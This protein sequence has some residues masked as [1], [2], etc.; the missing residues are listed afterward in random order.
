MNGTAQEFD[1]VV[2]GAGSA[3]CA[4]AARLAETANASVALIEAGPNDHHYTVSAP[5]GIAATVPREGP[6]NYAFHTEPQAG[7]LGR[8]SY[9]PRGRGLG[10]SSSINGMVYIRG[11]RVDFDAWANAGCTGWSYEDVLPY[12]R[13]SESNERCTGRDDDPCHGSRGPVQVSELRSPNPFS[14]HFIAAAL[15]AGLKLNPDFNGVDQEGVGL[16]Q[17]TQR[18]GERWNTARAYLHGGNRADTAH[19]GGRECL[20]VLTG[21][22]AQR[23][24][25]E[26][27]RAAAVE[28]WRDGVAQTVRV[29]REIVVSAGTFHSPQ[30]LMASGIGPAAHLREFGIEVVCDAPQV[31]QNLQD[32]LDIIVNKQVASTELFGRSVPGLMRLAREIHRYRR[33]RTGMITSN[34]AEAGAFV[35]SAPDLAAPDL[36]LHFVPAML[37]NR[38]E[39]KPPRGHGYSCHACVLRPHS[40]GEVTLRSPHMHDAP[41]ID[42]RFLADERDMAGMVA[43]VKLVRRIFAQDALARHGGREL[44][45]DDIAREAEDDEAIRAFVRR[46]ADTVYHPVGTCRMGADAQSVVDPQL[47]VRGVAGLRVVDASVMPTLVGGNTNAAAIMIAEKAADL[48]RANI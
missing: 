23:I 17:V 45:T 36:Q 19:N 14:Q 47:R 21:A 42:P 33:E 26:G 30:L 4:I 18:N 37:G 13:R 9:Q 12:F 34:L 39:G 8:R 46:N 15:Q 38:G 20:T 28:I 29:R 25:F 31:G 2:I 16:Y 6:R 35:R 7:L 5:L 48:M 1:Y 27:A 11:H 44:F 43:G 10:G 3:G 22:R 41:S 32:H 40:R 24:V